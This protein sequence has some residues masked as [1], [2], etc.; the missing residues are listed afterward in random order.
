MIEV[1][2]RIAPVRWRIGLAT[3]LVGALVA[4]VLGLLTFGVQ[5]TVAP[6]GVPLALV[7]PRGDAGAA[8]APMAQQIGTQGG[9]AVEWH[10]VD[11]VT[12]TE[13]LDD[14][15][16]YGILEIAPTSEG[17]AITTTTSGAVNPSGTQVAEQMLGRA[18]GA[19]AQAITQRTG[20]APAI[21]ATT[22]HPAPP[23]ARALPLVATALLWIGGLAANAV[24][25]L[26][27][28]RAGRG[29]PVGAAMVGAATIAVAGPA[30]ILGFEA[31]WGL[32]IDWTW[33]RW[34]SSPSSR[35]G[36]GS[37]RRRCCGW[38]GS[39]VSACLRC[40]T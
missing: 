37:C 33:G 28:A 19:I 10:V 25:L 20:V 1:R 15:E 5:T 12:A 27:F 22:V 17:L 39:R 7:I 8:L 38:P 13:L 40:C 9:D 16:V 35:A 4:V 36:S 29:L 23:A 26:R 30:V 24:L 34:A 18:G 32:G 11:A 6:R 2:A 31:L 21:T 14:A 3:G